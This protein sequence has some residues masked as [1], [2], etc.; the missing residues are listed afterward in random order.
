M[1]DDKEIKL[2][3]DLQ[4]TYYLAESKKDGGLIM[5]DTGNNFLIFCDKSSADNYFGFRAVP[6]KIVLVDDL[7]THIQDILNRHREAI[8]DWKKRTEE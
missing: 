7:T 5:D 6:V 1:S 3:L 8:P 4:K 2:R